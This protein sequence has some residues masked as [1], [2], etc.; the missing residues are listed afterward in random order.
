[1]WSLLFSR[2][3][4]TVR[5]WTFMFVWMIAAICGG[6]LPIFWGCT[7]EPFTTHGTSTHASWGRFVMNSIFMTFPLKVRS[8]PV[9]ILWMIPAPYSLLFCSTNF[10]SGFSS[11]SRR[12]TH[13]AICSSHRL[14]YSSRGIANSLR[15][16]S[17]PLFMNHGTYSAKCSLDSVTKN[18]VRRNTS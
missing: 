17:R 7:P 18:P 12:E 3:A 11:L 8:C 5:D 16:S 13:S 14:G 10:V 4:R 6:N 2:T 1:M 9:S 15:R